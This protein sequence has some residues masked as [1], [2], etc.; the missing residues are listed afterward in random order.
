[1]PVLSLSPSLAIVNNS[2]PAMFGFDVDNDMCLP[3]RT[4]AVVS[5]TNLVVDSTRLAGLHSGLILY[6][7][8]G[9]SHIKENG[10]NIV[11]GPHFFLT[12]FPGD[13]GAPTQ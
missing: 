9:Q 4:P 10:L 6:T 5:S 8:E 11:P 2:P 7:F 1:M 12:A 3:S 13:P